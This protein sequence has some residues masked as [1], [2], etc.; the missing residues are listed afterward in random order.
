[1]YNSPSS[2]ADVNVFPLLTTVLSAF[3][4]VPNI[5]S[6]V[7]VIVRL[8]PSTSVGAVSPK[9][10]SVLSSLTVMLLVSTTRESLTGVIL[11]SVLPL[12]VS[13]PSLTE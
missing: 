6:P 11:I 3:V 5:G 12:T 10:V 13:V 1:M 7:T 8:S 2:S 4:T 9:D